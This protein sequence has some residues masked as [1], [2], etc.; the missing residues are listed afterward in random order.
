MS[1]MPRAD[2]RVLFCY[3]G[4]LVLLAGFATSACGQI[5]EGQDLSNERVRLLIGLLDSNDYAT[6][7]RAELELSQAGLS[8]ISII[9]AAA[10][11]DPENA[12]RL[13]GVLE[14]LFVG[15]ADAQTERQRARSA[16]VP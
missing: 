10:R 11:R 12:A 8:N 5:V 13:V 7:N 16:C 15:G 2:T 3:F 6:R 4:P 14:R 9:E 1:V